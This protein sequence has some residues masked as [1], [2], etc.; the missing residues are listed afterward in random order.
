MFEVQRYNSE[1][2]SQWDSFVPKKNNGT[3]FH[4][5][6]FLSYHPKSRFHDHSLLFYK[7]KKLFSVFP[8]AQKKINKKLY[9]VSHPGA[10][11][12]SFV[13]PQDLSISDSLNL[14]KALK[15]YCKEKNFD[16]IQITT[17]PN[18]YQ[19]RLSNYIEFSFIKNKFFY[20]KREVTSI[21]HLENNIEKNLKKFKLSH[22]RAIKKGLKKGLVCKEHI[23]FEKFYIMLKKN[24]KKRHG[25]TPTH[26]LFELKK[27]YKIFP[28]KIKLFGSF[29]KGKMVAG[30]LNFI[31]NE[32]VVLAFYITHDEKYSD[33]RPLN[34]LFYNMFEWAIKLNFKIYDFGIFTVNGDPNMGLGRFKENF[35]A[36][37][38][39]RDTFELSL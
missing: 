17:P 12:G 10:T 9:I 29:Y 36:S 11:L 31:V 26:T 38:I 32:Q 15:N 16:V 22:K 14:V 25:V 37:G 30:V 6:S 7:K 35:G 1:Y 2:R 23:E 21:L 33:I 27:L 8:A 18:L 3:I 28:Q 39:F 4:L 19:H 13:L 24:L 20:S 5:R 34:I